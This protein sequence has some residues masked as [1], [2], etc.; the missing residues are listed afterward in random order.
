MA[1]SP[2][3][4]LPEASPIFSQ[5]QHP[6]LGPGTIEGL[7]LNKDT[8]QMP[9]EDILTRFPRLN[10]WL[11]YY[12]WLLSICTYDNIAPGPDPESKCF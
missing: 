1:K 3:S 2:C 11:S 7:L 5:D 6:E 4:P 12:P 10:V 9:Q 8:A